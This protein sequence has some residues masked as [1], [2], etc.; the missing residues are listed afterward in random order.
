VPVETVNDVVVIVEVNI[1]SLNDAVMTATPVAPLSGLVEL[2]VGAKV[3]ATGEIGLE[4][5][6]PAPTIRST[7]S[8]IAAMLLV[9]KC[10]SGSSC[11][12]QVERAYFPAT[13]LVVL[14]V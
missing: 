4:S 2:T 13:I 10:M 12:K 5:L 11:R 3:S 8:G 7:A 9:R 6:H 1:A 14:S